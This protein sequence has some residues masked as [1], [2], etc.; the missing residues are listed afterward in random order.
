MCGSRWGHQLFSL[1]LLA[2]SL[3]N[4]H[5][6]FKHGVSGP[7]Y[8]VSAS[9]GFLLVKA[10]RLLKTRGAHLRV[11]LRGVDAAVAE[12]AAHLR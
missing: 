6:F 7:V 9:R 11:D 8:F 4:F 5:K 1:V 12:Q 2:P 3:R 10:D